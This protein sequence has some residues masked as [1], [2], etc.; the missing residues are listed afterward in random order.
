MG[1]SIGAAAAPMTME[2]F[3]KSVEGLLA[4]LDAHAAVA[5]AEEL[6]NYFKIILTD[7]HLHSWRKYA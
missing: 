2:S 5:A 4:R 6:I 1:A 3:D 7:S